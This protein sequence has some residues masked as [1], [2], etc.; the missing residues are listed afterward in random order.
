V[1]RARLEALGITPDAIK[2]VDERADAI[3]AAAIDGAKNAPP[4]DVREAFTD[5]WADGGSAWRT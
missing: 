3:V 2:Q 5:V 4:A 1:A